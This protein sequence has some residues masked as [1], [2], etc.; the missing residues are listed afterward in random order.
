MSMLLIHVSQG[1]LALP[2]V[3]FG[4]S[5]AFLLPAVAKFRAVMT[6]T[7]ELV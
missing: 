4:R 2:L 3:M 7:E 6:F 5:W 1:M